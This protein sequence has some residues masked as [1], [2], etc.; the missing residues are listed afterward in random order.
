MRL[1]GTWQL[2][3]HDHVGYLALDPC[4]NENCGKLTLAAISD[5]VS[6]VEVLRLAWRDDCFLIRSILP[7]MLLSCPFGMGLAALGCESSIR[8]CPSLLTVRRGVA[9]SS[10]TR[11]WPS[12]D[13]MPG[14]SVVSRGEVCSRV[15]PIGVNG[16]KIGAAPPRA[17]ARA[18][19]A[20]SLLDLLSL[21]K[22]CTQNGGMYFNVNF[23]TH[24]KFKSTVD[25]CLSFPCR[26]RHDARFGLAGLKIHK[27][28]FIQIRICIPWPINSI[29]MLESTILSMQEAC[30][31]GKDVPIL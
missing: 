8:P 2:A 20:D 16:S 29:D 19:S 5:L 24:W 9:L 26:S 31:G 28:Q 15:Q 27:L 30:K 6:M 11:S 3:S 1:K 23:R 10:C 14:K 18:S 25:P 7:P 22:N 21:H 4:E 17:S 13:I 12:E